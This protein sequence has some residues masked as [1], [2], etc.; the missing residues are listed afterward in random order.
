MYNTSDD[1]FGY[2]FSQ[3]TDL[4]SSQNMGHSS[5]MSFRDPDAPDKVFGLNLSFSS[6]G[7]DTQDDN[8]KATTSASYIGV[9]FNWFVTN[10]VKAR[11]VGGY[12]FATGNSSIL[13]GSE[14][15]PYTGPSFDEAAFTFTPTDHF[16][17][18][19]GI[20]STDFNTVSSTFA[21]A[22]FAGL[23]EV[24]NWNNGPYMGSLRGYQVAPSSLGA[25]NRA[26][27]DEKNPFLTIA[28]INTGVKLSRFSTMLA[29][30]KYDFYGMSS[31]S[32]AD[33]RYLGNTVVG[34][35]ND[36]VNYKYKFRGNEVAA[37]AQVLFRLDD[38]LG[39]TGNLTKNDEAPD[40]RNR[41]WLVRGYYE[42]NYGRYSI[43][44][45]ITRFRFESDLMPA[46]FS[47]GG[48]GYLNRDGYAGEIRGAL[49]KYRLEAYVRYLDA[50]EIE[51]K[52]AQSDRTS[53][54]V[55]MEVKYEVL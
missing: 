51:P 38:K 25:A 31:A 47:Q 34:D 55:G 45:A 26:L 41:G 22:G 32:A 3:P 14:T 23:R 49:K 37:N 35:G 7:T 46:F 33:S 18:S 13:Y 4:S 17:F 11:F 15:Y 42:Y 40:K 43:R 29:Y 2:L 19:S 30:T 44:P 1:S 50:K 6:R 8:V 39:V 27:D 21:G 10:W 5:R 52:P 54:T 28:N 9:Q 24:Y 20:V 36:I 12:Q 53:V 48:L 16:E